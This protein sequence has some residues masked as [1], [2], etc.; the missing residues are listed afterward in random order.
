MYG[1]IKSAQLCTEEKFITGSQQDVNF[2]LFVQR[3]KYMRHLCGLFL[4]ESQSGYR[5]RERRSDASST[6]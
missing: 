3:L 5:E 6:R 4:L 1:L 2:T